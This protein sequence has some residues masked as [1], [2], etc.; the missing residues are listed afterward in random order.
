MHT[1]V[2][3]ID[4]LETYRTNLAPV[5]FLKRGFAERFSD[6]YA[7]MVDV[8]MRQDRPREALTAAER[9]R[10]RAFADLLAAQRAK[11]REE[12]DT[13][14]WL[15]G[16]AGGL[17]ATP[18]D[19]GQPPCGSVARCQRPR[20]LAERLSSTLVV[21]WSIRWARTL[22]RDPGRRSP[23]A[24]IRDS[25]PG[26]RRAVQKA[27]DVA[28]ELENSRSASGVERACPPARCTERSM[29]RS[30]HRLPPSSPR[31]PTRESR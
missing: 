4:R 7:L 30:G 10:S 24:P 15:L 28:P 25:V 14:R 12:A 22:G 18:S 9:A 21:Y 5:D 20:R 3:V 26:L 8:Q 16:G 23:G 11:E 2:D 17:S 31:L 6:A 1:L 13:E 19:L 27:V 29:R